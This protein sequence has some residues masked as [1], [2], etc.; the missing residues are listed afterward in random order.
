M[1]SSLIFSLCAS[2][3]SAEFVYA[4][5][6]YSVRNNF[7]DSNIQS[8]PFDN[9]FFTASVKANTRRP[10]YGSDFTLQFVNKCP[11]TIKP[12][13]VGNVDNSGI[14]FF[15]RG[16]SPAADY[17]LAPGQ[18]SEYIPLPGN[19]HGRVWA[20]ARCRFIKKTNSWDCPVGD[21]GNTLFEY[22]A[23]AGANGGFA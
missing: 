17:T 15:G 13:L 5:H 2:S 21:I 6:D 7:T 18:Q 4:P 19:I 22:N 3:L 12:Q 8:A 11:F 10:S 9:G 16:D 20:K 23:G 14:N 1:I